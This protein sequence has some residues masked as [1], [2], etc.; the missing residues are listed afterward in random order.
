VASPDP[1]QAPPG[2]AY[3]AIFLDGLN[4]VCTASRLKSTVPPDERAQCALI[5]PYGSNQEYRREAPNKM[6]NTDH[7][8]RCSD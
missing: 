3:G 8:L 7:L 6:A 1:P 5:D 4:K 2:A